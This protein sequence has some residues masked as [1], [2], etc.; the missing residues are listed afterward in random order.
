MGKVGEEKRPRGAESLI[1][2]SFSLICG[3]RLWE[4]GWIAEPEG[5]CNLATGYCIDYYLYSPCIALRLEL[6]ALKRIRQPKFQRTKN[7]NKKNKMFIGAR[8]KL[9]GS[10]NEWWIKKIKRIN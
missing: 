8:C 1:R 2:G 4:R 6:E 7:K 9:E 3:D 5:G 10:P